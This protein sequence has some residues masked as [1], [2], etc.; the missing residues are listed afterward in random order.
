MPK[1][2]ADKINTAIGGKKGMTGQYTVDC[3]ARD[4]F[5]EI[6]FKLPKGD[7]TFRSTA[8]SLDMLEDD[9]FDGTLILNGFDYTLEVQGTCISG[10]MGV[11]LPAHIPWIVGDVLLR[12]YYSIYDLENNRV[13]F[14]LA[15]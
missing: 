3:N 12:K 4:S 15:K 1:D 11:D 14:A 7:K 2:V 5:P 8:E 9:K 13:G 6:R 10:F